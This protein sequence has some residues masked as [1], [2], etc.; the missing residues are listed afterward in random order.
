MRLEDPKSEV[1]ITDALKSGSCELMMMESTTFFRAYGPVLL[2]LQQMSGD[3]LGFAEQFATV[4]PQHGPPRYIAS[5]ERDVLDSAV[6]KAVAGL[7]R[8]QRAVSI[9]FCRT[10]GDIVG[11][12]VSFNVVKLSS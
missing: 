9:W 5:A 4:T 1:L 2:S 8:T 10:Y 12:C 7:D 6:R 3:N 11:L